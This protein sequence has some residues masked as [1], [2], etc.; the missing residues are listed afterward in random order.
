MPK[1]IDKK[2]ING[3]WRYFYDKVGKLGGS[4]KVSAIR[5]SDAARRG[6]TAILNSAKGAKKRLVAYAT[7]NEL[8]KERVRIHKHISNGSIK[9]INRRYGD[10][11]NS[12]S[13]LLRSMSNADK[14]YYKA[15]NATIAANK[16]GKSQTEYY[17]NLK[18]KQD[19]REG[20]KKAVNFYK[21]WQEFNRQWDKKK[22]RAAEQRRKD[23]LDTMTSV[24]RSAVTA[25]R[26][27]RIAANNATIAAN[28]KGKSQTEYYKNKANKQASKKAAKRQA[29]LD[30]MTS[31]SKSD[32]S[33]FSSTP[34]RPGY[35]DLGID[36]KG[37]HYRLNM[38]KKG[39]KKTKKGSRSGFSWS[40]K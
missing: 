15:H 17:K 12:P 18:K 26:D 39:K 14:K 19:I 24:S 2:W 11:S 28:R 3:K 13:M 23:A 30:R 5:A 40:Y 35:L 32:A 29:D 1:F 10:F 36:K 7:N 34:R 31:T 22:K 37:I 8:G 33:I 38:G 21:G 20:S 16:K 4:A 6:A 9:N 27:A 25:G